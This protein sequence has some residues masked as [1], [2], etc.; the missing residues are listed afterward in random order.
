MADGARKLSMNS[1]DTN[2]CM[3]YDRLWK[4]LCPKAL[5]WHKIKMIHNFTCIIYILLEHYFHYLH[6][7][8]H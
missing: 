7:I 2:V 5:F 8:E 4:E 3:K 1:Q 6:Y